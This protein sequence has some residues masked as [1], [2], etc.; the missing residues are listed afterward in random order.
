MLAWVVAATV[1]IPPAPPPDPAASSPAPRWPAAVLLI[2]GAMGLSV[3]LGLALTRA[4]PSCSAQDRVWVSIGAG[5]FAATLLIGGIA[6]LIWSR[7][8][9]E[10][11]PAG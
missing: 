1:A 6:W 3:A 5:T 2:G 10:E 11:E 9:L 4:C 8:P 7:P